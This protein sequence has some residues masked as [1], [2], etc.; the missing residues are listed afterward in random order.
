MFSSILL[1]F[2]GGATVWPN[3]GVSVFPDKGDGIY[4]YNLQRKDKVDYDLMHKAC[5]VLLGTKWICNKWIGF[6]SQWNQ[7]NRNCGIM[8]DELHQPNFEINGYL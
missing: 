3:I 5:P 7:K 8:E 2:L 1:C 6:K 4:W